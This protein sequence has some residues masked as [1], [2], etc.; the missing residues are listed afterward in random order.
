MEFHRSK[1]HDKVKGQMAP[2]RIGDELTAPLADRSRTS[3]VQ[4]R[5]IFKFGSNG[6]RVM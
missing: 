5:L 2:Q 6:V 4:I 1:S 3:I